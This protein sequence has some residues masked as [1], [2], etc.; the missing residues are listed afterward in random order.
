MQFIDVRD[1]ADVDRARRRRRAR[2]RV[3]RHGR[4]DALRRPAR[5]VRARITGSDAS[6]TWVPSETLLAAGVEEWMGVPLWIVSPGWESANRV[7]GREGGRGRPHVPAAR[8]DDPRRARRGGPVD[9][10]GLTPEREREL[11]ALSS[12]RSRDSPRVRPE[13]QSLTRAP[14]EAWASLPE[15]R[16]GSSAERGL[17][18]GGGAGPALVVA[19]DAIGIDAAVLRRDRR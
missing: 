3:Q 15:L 4:A 6:F 17:R 8:G 5:R 1:L 19:A 9:G 10:V 12:D 11:L 2:R 18:C 7:A 16:A 13:G 14:R